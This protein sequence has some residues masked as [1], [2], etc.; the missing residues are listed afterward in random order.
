MDIE[1]MT[2]AELEKINRDLSQ[3]RNALKEQQRKVVLALDRKR[4]IEDAEAKVAAMPQAEKD[5]LTQA[6]GLTGV[7]E[8]PKIGEL[9][10]KSFIDR[11]L[12]R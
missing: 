10:K 6:L 9:G 11:V 3:Q 7:K 5:A 1:N 12:G 2:V 4:A 8:E